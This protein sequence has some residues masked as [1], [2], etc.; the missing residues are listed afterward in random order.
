MQYKV[1]AG[2]KIAI[3]ELQNLGDCDQ[4]KDDLIKI[5]KETRFYSR[6]SA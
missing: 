6:D 3:K 1:E 5:L 4:N 2:N